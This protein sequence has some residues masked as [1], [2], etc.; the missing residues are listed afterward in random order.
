MELAPTAPHA[1]FFFVGGGVVFAF[2]FRL[3]IRLHQL[4][5]KLR[6]RLGWDKLHN[7]G[8]T[9]TL[10]AKPLGGDAALV[11]LKGSVFYD[12]L[13]FVVGIIMMIIVVLSLEP[14]LVARIFG[15]AKVFISK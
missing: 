7:L 9:S 13:G 12:I 1:I 11:P 5:N 2:W 3:F 14:E 15:S 4:L 6:N 10:F 8:S